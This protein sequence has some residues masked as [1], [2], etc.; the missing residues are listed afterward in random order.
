MFFHETGNTDKFNMFKDSIHEEGFHKN[1]LALKGINKP[2]IATI[3]ALK[4]S[5][6]FRLLPWLTYTLDILDISLMKTCRKIPSF[7]SLILNYIY[8]PYS[9]WC[10]IHCYW[11]ESKLK[12]KMDSMNPVYILS[13]WLTIQQYWFPL[14][15]PLHAGNEMLPATDGIHEAFN[16]P[17]G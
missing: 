17:D 8:L 4:S 3:S 14:S 1:L 13:A 6:D 16:M 15:A 11:L 12:D 9:H 5:N 2:F 7:S 10:I